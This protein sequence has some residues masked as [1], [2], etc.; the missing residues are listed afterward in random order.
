[1]LEAVENTQDFVR[2]VVFDTWVINC[3]RHYPD[4]TVRK[5]NH[6]NVFLSEEGAAPGHFRLKAMDHTHCFGCRTGELKKN[7]AD[8]DHVR[9]EKIDGLFPAFRRFIREQEV[10]QACARFH[11]LERAQ[12]ERVVGELPREWEVSQEQRELLITQIIRRAAYLADALPNRLL[13]LLTPG[14]SS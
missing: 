2:L 7:I 9:D 4:E 6:D 14:A 3:D 5:P 1:M 11:D 13:P 12:V 8:L 10:R